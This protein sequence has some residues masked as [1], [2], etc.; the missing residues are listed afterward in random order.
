MLEDLLL[1]MEQFFF[2]NQDVI[3][4]MFCQ[5]GAGTKSGDEIIKPCHNFS[6][7]KSR[8]NY[9]V[10]A[11]FGWKICI[12]LSSFSGYCIFYSCVIFM[13]SRYY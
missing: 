12:G 11:K 9:P 8:M 2:T 13:P 1:V 6:A 7:R 10:F 4:A 3:V 5:I